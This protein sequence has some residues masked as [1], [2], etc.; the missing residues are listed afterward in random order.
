MGLEI[1]HE[2]NLTKINFLDVTFDL[3]RETSEQY[4]K[5]N[6]YPQYVHTDS[7][8]PRSVLKNI[9]FAVNKD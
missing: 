1:T 3:S 2:K 9:P 5:P 6:D 7:N 4:R 8:H